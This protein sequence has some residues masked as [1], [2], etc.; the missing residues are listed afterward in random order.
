MPASQ[1]G[2]NMKTKIAACLVVAFGI[3]G[4]VWA[5]TATPAAGAPVSS[6]RAASQERKRLREELMA[7]LNLTP[8]QQAKLKAHEQ[9]MKSKRAEWNKALSAATPE[10]QKAMKKDMRKREE[11]FLK[12][13]LTKAQYDE[14]KSILAE[15]RKAKAAI[16]P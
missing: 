15:Q 11:D 8:D 14:R 16:K 5:Q 4:G 2:R 3:V 7:K 1:K 13:T 6:A 12:A 9:E 10:Q